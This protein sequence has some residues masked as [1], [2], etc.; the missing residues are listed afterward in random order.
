MRLHANAA[1]GLNKRRLF[2]RRVVEERWT[3][4][5][6]AAGAEVSVPCARKWDSRYRA[7]LP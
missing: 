4:T 3:L 7:G 1:L 5:E 2:A 6:A